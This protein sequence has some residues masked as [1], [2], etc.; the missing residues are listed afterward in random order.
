MAATFR[1]KKGVLMEIHPMMNFQ[2]GRGICAHVHWISK[3]PEEMEVLFARGIGVTWKGE[4]IEENKEC[5][6]IVKLEMSDIQ[7]LGAYHFCMVRLRH[8]NFL[9]TLF[10]LCKG[11]TAQR[12]QNRI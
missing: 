10:H 1:G 5:G 4:I 8:E 6:Q 7:W 12:S 3:W 11:V 2:G 9:Y